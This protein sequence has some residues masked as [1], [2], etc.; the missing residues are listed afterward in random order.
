MACGGRIIVRRMEYD[1]AMSRTETSLTTVRPA[2]TTERKRGRKPVAR[3]NARECRDRITTW[4]LTPEERRQPATQ[5]ELAA[6]LGISKQMASYYAQQAPASIE[7]L[8]D[9]A[10][11][12]ALG[13]YPGILKTLSELAEKGS[14]EAIK[15]YIRELA[16][17][18]RPVPPK[19]NSSDVSLTLAIQNLMQPPKE[20]KPA[21]SYLTA[22]NVP[23][24]VS[25]RQIPSNSNCDGKSTS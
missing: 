18:H 17:P 13:H 15:V 7:E 22:E 14:V 24:D 8:V 21:N 10:E 25:K 20:P 11:R 23:A 12:K 5:A 4:K 16:G 6:Q 19:Q 1:N 9:S 2:L 3:G